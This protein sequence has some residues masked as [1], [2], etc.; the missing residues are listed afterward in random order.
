MFNNTS[1]LKTKRLKVYIFKHAVPN[2]AMINHFSFKQ[3]EFGKQN[4]G[5]GK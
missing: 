4:P 5:K 3:E 2:S 1:L